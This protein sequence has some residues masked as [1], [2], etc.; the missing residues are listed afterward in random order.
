MNKLANDKRFTTQTFQKYSKH[1]KFSGPKKAPL[2]SNQKLKDDEG[3]KKNNSIYST[4]L[5]FFF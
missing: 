4:F 5:S 2:K 1:P 3:N